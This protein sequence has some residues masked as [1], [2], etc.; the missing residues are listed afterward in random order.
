MG[1]VPSGIEK[2]VAYLKLLK[3]PGDPAYDDVRGM[4][5]EHSVKQKMMSKVKIDDNN[6][7]D[8]ELQGSTAWYKKVI[9]S[10]SSG[11][12]KRSQVILILILIFLFLYLFLCLY[13]YL[14]L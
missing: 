3:A 9:K 2:Q 8:N 4:A 12:F 10:E 13:L 5:L 6:D 1:F 14:Y 11:I 7:N